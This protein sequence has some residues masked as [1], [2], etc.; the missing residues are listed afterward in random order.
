[1]ALRDPVAR[2]VFYAKMDI[3]DAPAIIFFSIYTSQLVR[4]TFPHIFA[5]EIPSSRSRSR[6]SFAIPTSSLI[7]SPP[8]H[9]L[10]GLYQTFHLKFQLFDL[11]K[12]GRFC[13]SSTFRSFEFVVK[14]SELCGKQA[15]RS[16]VIRKAR[17]KKRTFGGIIRPQI[18]LFCEFSFFFRSRC[19]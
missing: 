10:K 7:A 9:F 12:K 8:A 19:G 11:S 17:V 3:F 6:S 14:R 2:C 13:F 1:M 15:W 18:E 4:Q 5:F 16:L